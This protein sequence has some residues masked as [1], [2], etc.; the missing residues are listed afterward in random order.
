[1]LLLASI[2]TTIILLLATHPIYVGVLGDPP[3]LQPP[4]CAHEPC[5]SSPTGDP[6]FPHWK[7]PH[8]NHPEKIKPWDPGLPKPY[9]PKPLPPLPPADPHPSKHEL[10]PNC[11]G[12]AIC[13]MKLVREHLNYA[14][15]ITE[16]I[17]GNGTKEGSGIDPTRWYVR[18]EEIACEPI[19]PFL[20]K[21]SPAICALLKHTYGA[22]GRHIIRMAPTIV[23]INK[24]KR[25][26]SVP[27]DWNFTTGKK[28]KDVGWAKGQGGELTFNDV[29]IP[30]CLA[31]GDDG[32][33]RPGGGLCEGRQGTDYTR[34][35][36]LK[37]PDHDRT[38]YEGMVCW[39]T[40]WK[41]RRDLEIDG[42]GEEDIREKN[43]EWPLEYKDGYDR[44][45][46]EGYDE[47]Y[48]GECQDKLGDDGELLQRR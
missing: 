4:P 9:H 22:F 32:I 18:Q 44:E 7:P 31:G 11:H 27:M 46:G 6:L 1:M 29:S 17:V 26:G 16:Y 35:G 41:T 12:S 30:L 42:A 10:V 47:E 38:C 23:G 8:I 43:Q 20:G 3:P 39:P 5:S 13:G 34:M 19:E 37:Y 40:S 2:L 28:D 15:I 14:A 48:S 21:D 36:K 33:G 45:Y 25:C 24:C